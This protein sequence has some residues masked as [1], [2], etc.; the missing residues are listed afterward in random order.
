MTQLLM[1]QQMNFNFFEAF[2]ETPKTS[3]SNISIAE[4]QIACHRMSQMIIIFFKL[5]LILQNPYQH[6]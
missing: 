2:L 5:R 4:D 3:I 1:L 6:N